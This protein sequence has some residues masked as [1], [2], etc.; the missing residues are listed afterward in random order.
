LE[1]LVDPHTE[2][3]G[4]S[5]DSSKGEDGG[6]YLRRLK[7]DPAEGAP[8]D[9]AAKGTGR[10][11]EA[12]ATPVLKERRQSPRLRCSGSV[13]FR[14][15]DNNARK[16]GTLTDVSLHGCYVEMNTTFPVDT[17]VD[18]V[19]KSFGIRIQ[20]SGTVRAA[21]PFVGM[22]IRFAELD[23]TEKVQLKRLLAALAGRS[24]ASNGGPAEENSMKETLKAADP[25]AFLDE[26]AA[27]FQKS[28]LLSREE[29][30][31]IAKRVRRS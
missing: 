6:N 8:A 26:I 22:G 15:E 30:H 1:A 29:F 5:P 17:R 3:P 20:A 9:A 7:G 12:T 4:S 31:Q 2:Q 28:P 27:F 11:P 13:E 25:R 14:A 21:Y 18:L 24:A 10:N 16:W 23:A 19:L